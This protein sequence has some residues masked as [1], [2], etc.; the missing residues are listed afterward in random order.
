LTLAKDTNRFTN[1][2]AIVR[3]KKRSPE[4]GH[5]GVRFQVTGVRVR[6]WIGD[7]M[8]SRVLVLVY[9]ISQTIEHLAK[10]PTAN[11][12]LLHVVRPQVGES[13]GQLHLGI[14]FG[15]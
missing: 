11:R 12:E 5:S 6:A 8:N 10:L 7:L 2:Q 13:L 14:Q 1:C 3:K 15:Q 9:R 4:M